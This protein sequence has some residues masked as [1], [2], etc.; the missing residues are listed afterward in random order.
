MIWRSHPFRALA[1]QLQRPGSDT[2]GGPPGSEKL[3]A[4][5]WLRS[6]PS[7][8]LAWALGHPGDGMP[9]PNDLLKSWAKTDP[10]SA[11][12][13]ALEMGAEG[14]YSAGE[15]CLVLA[16]SNPARAQA[17]WNALPQAAKDRSDY[18]FIM[19]VACAGSPAEMA[20]LF[21]SGKV[22]W[23]IRRGM[24]SLSPAKSEMFRDA[25]ASLPPGEARQELMGY[26][27]EHL[28]E[29]D[30]EAALAWGEAHEPTDEMRQKIAEI[31]AVKNPVEAW[32]LAKTLTGNLDR[33]RTA[34]IEA[35]AVKDPAAAFELAVNANTGSDRDRGEHLEALCGR[36]PGE[37]DEALAARFLTI[38]RQ[39][40]ERSIPPAALAKAAASAL[41]DAALRIWLDAQPPGDHAALAAAI[42]ES[43]KRTSPRTSAAFAA[44]AWSA[45][46]T[47]Q[48]SAPDK[49][50]ST[51]RSLGEAYAEWAGD[52]PQAA[53]AAALNLPQGRAR[54]AA[55]ANTAVNWFFADAPAA[56]AWLESRAPGPAR[57]DATMAI[58]KELSGTDPAAAARLVAALSTP[59]AREEFLKSAT[60]KHPTTAF[61]QALRQA[62]PQSSW[63]PQEQA[64]F[65]GK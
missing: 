14:Y 45:L 5:Q 44:E 31:M 65:L 51:L 21:K 13:A 43:K 63:T 26:I 47:D 60:A 50:P 46:P 27:T 36:Q 22:D 37:S 3:L 15:I 56:T 25:A 1:I 7:A 20:A 18:G 57:D 24:D 9:Y 33:V 19:A 41:D 30:P 10:E 55:V 17:L 59:K 23:S 28:A 48:Q 11:M 35:L 40:G 53:A 38:A 4:A 34:V 49:T 6:D 54:D 29:K 58:S 2:S 64:K 61:A 32:E 8:C 12:K 16:A 42:S 39:C 62:L 52:E